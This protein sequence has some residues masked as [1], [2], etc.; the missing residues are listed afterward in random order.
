MLVLLASVFFSGI[1]T[2]LY[3]LIPAVRGLAWA[4]PVTYGIQLLQSVMLRGALPEWRL[5]GGLLLIGLVLFVIAWLLTQRLMAR[6]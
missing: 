1:F 6:R 2:A 4:L 3:L 5:L